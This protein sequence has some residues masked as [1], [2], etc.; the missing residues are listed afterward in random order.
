MKHLAIF[1]ATGKTGKVL[2]PFALKRNYH[3]TALVRDPG[4]LK[5]YTN[6]VSII[7]GDILD[8]SKVEEALR[9]VDGVILVI[10]HVKGSPRDLQQKGITNVIQAMNGYGIRRLIT[11]TGRGVTDHQ[12]DSPTLFDKM[13]DSVTGL[14]IK[15]AFIDGNKHVEILKNSALNWT[16]VRAPILLPGNGKGRYKTGYVGK[17]GMS[18][19]LTRKDL[20]KAILDILE[21]NTFIHEMPY[22]S[23]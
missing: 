18:L 6:S 7:K 12:N 17:K 5:E 1:G 23:N 2:L 14:I 13:F 4:K 9:G 15:D 3:V 16:V 20:S 22:I 21:N 11:L 8:Y 10:G 19:L